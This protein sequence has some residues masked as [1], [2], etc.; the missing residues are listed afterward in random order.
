[1]ES[2][3]KGSNTPTNNDDKQVE[4]LEELLRNLTV[5]SSVDL[6]ELL[7]RDEE[8]AFSFR[9]KL[10]FYL[11]AFIVALLGNLCVI[12]VILRTK[13]L[14]TKFN[15]YIV[16]LALADLM[17]PLFCM[18]IQLVASLNMQWIL[19][20]FLCKIHTFVQGKCR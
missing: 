13:S 14:R 4:Y 11:L 8:D 9:M 15:M 2:F 18:W 20:K 16:N 7:H 3:K 10:G 6:N 17:I 1:M 19:G 5:N 12:T